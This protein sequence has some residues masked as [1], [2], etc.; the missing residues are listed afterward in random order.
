MN[1]L[2]IFL[3]ETIRPRALIFGIASPISLVVDIYTVCSNYAPEAKIALSPGTHG[4]HMNRTEQNRILLD[5]N[6]T[7]SF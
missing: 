2:K 5:I 4:L 7:I 1:I 6:Y 3:S